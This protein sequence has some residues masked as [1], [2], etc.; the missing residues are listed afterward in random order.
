LAN[1]PRDPRCAHRLRRRR[2]DGFQRR[3]EVVSGD[4]DLVGVIVGGLTVLVRDALDGD[5]G[6]LPAQR[7]DLS[8]G[9]P[10]GLVG[11]VL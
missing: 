10:L 2:A 11:E 5:Q 9:V 6:G 4:P 8:A 1:F 3:R 7:G